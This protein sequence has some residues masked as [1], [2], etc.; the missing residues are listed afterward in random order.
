MRNRIHLHLTAVLIFAIL[1]AC[2]QTPQSSPSSKSKV[3]L[4]PRGE[5]RH[6][7]KI[8][9]KYDK[10]KDFSAM[11]L[12]DMII[13]KDL[14]LN[15]YFLYKGNDMKVTPPLVHLRF[16]SKST[17][18][19]YLDHSSLDLILN[20]NIRLNLGNLK[21]DG[22]VGSGYVLEFMYADLPVE[23][24]LQIATAQKVEGKLFTTEFTLK[25]EQIEALK[26]LASR[27]SPEENAS[28]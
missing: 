11:Q 7:Y 18:W 16:L 28:K 24:F 25:P 10:F 21:H 8:D 20:D 4:P 19:K 1:A 23:T 5:Y 12:D 2:G 15:A 6:P 26:D 22:T 14:K 3:Q 17:N 27:L 13:S 9:Y